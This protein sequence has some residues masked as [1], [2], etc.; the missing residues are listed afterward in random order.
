MTDNADTDNFR[1]T[2]QGPDRGDSVDAVEVSSK[3]TIQVVGV[4]SA[5]SD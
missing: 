3:E 1:N 5:A 4:I 2:I